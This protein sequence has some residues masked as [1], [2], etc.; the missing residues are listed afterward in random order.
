MKKILA[1][2]MVLCM[3]SGVALAEAATELNWA[4]MEPIIEA[5]GVTGDFVTFDE[6]AVKIWIPS[7]LQPVELTDDDRANGFI[8]YFA[9]AEQTASLS[10]VYVNVEGMSIEDYAAQLAE[11]EGVAEIETGTVNGLPC[12][13]YTMPEQDSGHISFATE[14]GFILE[15]SV[16]PT[17][18]EGADLVWGI[19]LGSIQAE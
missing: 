1:I 10:V 9:D 3:F 8:G 18:A 14:A 16:W 11:M 12:V 15:V 6:I 7:D 2:L 19:V 4:D 13:T 17:S 5:S